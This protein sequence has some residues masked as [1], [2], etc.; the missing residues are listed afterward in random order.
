[1]RGGQ[2]ESTV[3]E[4]LSHSARVLLQTLKDDKDGALASLQNILELDPGQLRRQ[5]EHTGVR[6]AEAA[7]CTPDLTL[8]QLRLGEAGTYADAG[9]VEEAWFLVESEGTTTG[10]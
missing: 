10:R 3:P 9:R 8:I 2:G 5:I 4:V 7:S 6:L 1:M